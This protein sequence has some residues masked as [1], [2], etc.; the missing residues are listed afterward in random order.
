[1]AGSLI[2]WEKQAIGKLGLALML[3]LF[4]HLSGRAIAAWGCLLEAS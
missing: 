1:M 2:H 4:V 3:G